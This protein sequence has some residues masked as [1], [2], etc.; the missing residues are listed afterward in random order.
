MELIHVERKARSWTFGAFGGTHGYLRI[1]GAIA[2]LR[3]EG[4]TPRKSRWIE[5]A[6]R[7]K[8]RITVEAIIYFMRRD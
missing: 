1:S 3:L 2:V 8:R 6:R 7:T 4:R 5:V